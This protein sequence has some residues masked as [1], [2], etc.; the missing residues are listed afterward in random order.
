MRN[1][2]SPGLLVSSLWFVLPL[3]F[4][5]FFSYKTLFTYW[6]EML[7]YPFFMNH[8]FVPYRDFSMVYTPLLPIFLQI[9]YRFIGYD[10]QILHYLGTLFLSLTVGTAM[11]TIHYYS[12]DKLVSSLLGLS[13]GYTLLSFEGNQF[14]FDSLLPLPFLAIFLLEASFASK[15]QW[16]K[17]AL[18]GLISTVTILVKQ[19][20]ALSLLAFT[21]YL[22]LLWHKKEFNLHKLLITF[23]WFVVPLLLVLSI[24]L[25]WLISKNILFDFWNWGIKFVLIIP[26]GNIIGVAPYLRLPT[27]RQFLAVGLFLLPPIILALRKNTL[28][29]I[30]L[31]IWV[32]ITFLLAFPNFAYSRLE[33]SLVFSFLALGVILVDKQPSRRLLLTVYLIVTFVVGTSIFM[34]HLRVDQQYYDKDVV[35]VALY[36]NQHYS[37]QSLYSFHGPDLVYVLTKRPPAFKPWL[38]QLS[39]QMAYAGEENLR[40]FKVSPPDVVVYRP[41]SLEIPQEKAILRYFESSYRKVFQTQKGTEI[42]EKIP[43]LGIK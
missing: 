21:L 12:K 39:W 40:A 31:V 2:S 3:I 6:P 37:S 27:I 9:I 24:F 16:W 42:L 7:N 18:A 41:S 22:L 19:T 8:G 13:L 10:P 5:I 11:L 1:K 32:L 15:P 36:I 25:V 28:P 34:R 20:A 17:M 35:E 4:I 30:L 33:S 26:R 23:F 43:R 14:W 38:D 29:S